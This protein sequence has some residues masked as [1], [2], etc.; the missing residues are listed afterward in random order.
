[1][2]TLKLNS[3]GDEVRTLQRA[4]GVTAD[5]QFG[6]KTE[7]AVKAF[8]KAHG[9]TSDG[10]VGPKTWEALG[11]KANTEVSSNS[12]QVDPSVIYKPLN[13]HITPVSSRK[14]EYLVIHF[15]AG[16]SS[17]P[18]SA[19][20]VYNVFKSREASADFAVDDS[21]MVQFNPDLNKNYCWAVGDGKG[22]YG[23]TNKNSISIEICSNLT[24]GTSAAVPNHEGWYFT[25]KSLENALKLS[26]ILMK[27][28]NIPANKV[29]R[30]Y[31][32]TRKACPGLVGWNDAGLY[33]SKTGKSNGKK[34][35][36][37]KWL[38]FKN[39]L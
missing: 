28:F 1:M 30:H 12:K 3:K 5:G 38:D 15:T 14:I 35:N 13:V 33:D 27:K 16:A 23:V 19:L 37:D 2:T 21:D 20:K 18:G 39:K 34:N 24:K 9:L 17:A 6:A 11:V 31:D 29:I 32:A 7:A 10:I 26:K 4:L 8:Q 25:D 22:K 36:S